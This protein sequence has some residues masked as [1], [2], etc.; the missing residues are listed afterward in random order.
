MRAF[1]L[2][3]PDREDGQQGRREHVGGDH[4]EADRKGQGEEECLG[5][6]FHEQRGQ[7]DGHDAR[8]GQET[9]TSGG[10]DRIA[11][12][13]R[14][15]SPL[16]ALLLDGFDG[17]SGFVHE[18]ADRQGE[19]AQGHEV[20]GLPAEPEAEEGDEQGKGD[21]DDDDQRAAGVTQEQEDHEAGQHGAEHGFEEEVM[22]GP[23]DDR[24]LVH[25]VTDLDVRRH[26]VLEDAEVGFDDAGHGQGRSIG[27][28]GDGDV[29]GAT[30]VHEGITGHGVRAVHDLRD[31]PDEHGG[32]LTRTD[33]DVLEVLDVLH[34]GVDGDEEVL[35]AEHDIA[36]GQD[37]VGPGERGGDFFGR[38]TGAAQAVRVEVDEDGA[39]TAA[40]GRGSGDAGQ[41]GE[42]RTDGVQRGVLQLR[43]GTG[44]AREDELADRH[45]AGVETHD[46]RGYGA[47]RHHGAG[48]V[49]VTD[50]L[51]HGL[52]H[53]RPGMEL[54]LHHRR[55]LDV[56][57][58]DV[59]D[60][61]DVQEVV[62]VIEGEEAF[63]LRGVHAAERLGHVDRRDVQ[64]REDVLGHAVQ[65]EQ[66][67]QDQRKDRDD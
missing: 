19:A 37:G 28:L 64:G 47:G 57:R 42:E 48:T 56:L 61:G 46:E 49:H 50:G 36:S 40:E 17:D 26:G 39:R 23:L 30:S 65:A 51:A 59:L 13:P 54:E 35:V 67:G 21:V 6:A 60:A 10:R 41:G 15:G 34:R 53:V 62:F 8:H 9:R 45:A 3:Q 32:V 12:G 25:F 27:A 18:D 4:A 33:G 29:D 20:D 24:T 7:E 31:V 43:D 55:A 11:D 5:R 14:D 58:F 1:V 63:H 2:E 44:L 22:D 16:L 66:G 52:R 38:Y